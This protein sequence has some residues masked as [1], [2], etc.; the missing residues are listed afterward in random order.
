MSKHLTSDEIAAA[1]A[2]LELGTAARDHLVGCVVCRTEIAELEGLIAARR[3]EISAD[4]P[5]WDDQASRIL[6]RLPSDAVA[7]SRRRPRW[8]RPALAVAATV[9]IALGLGWL[10]SSGPDAPAAETPSV[11]DILAEMN[12][13]LADDSIPGFEIIDP[14]ENELETYFDNG[15]S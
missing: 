2:G 13:L 7:G 3:D 8:L 6:A 10:R 9:I 15:A 5:D 14:E 4:A 11:E 12:E 1:V